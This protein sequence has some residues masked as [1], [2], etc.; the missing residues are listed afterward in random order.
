MRRET[1][2]IRTI[3]LLRGLSRCGAARASTVQRL[4][5][6]ERLGLCRD[7][8][9]DAFLAEANAIGAAAV[10]GVFKPGA[11]DLEPALSDANHGPAQVGTI[12]EPFACG[13]TCKLSLCAVLVPTAQ[14]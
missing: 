7:G 10:L 13:N 14:R 6:H 3:K 8:S 5:G 1:I 12:H 2:P 11:T 9:E 4:C